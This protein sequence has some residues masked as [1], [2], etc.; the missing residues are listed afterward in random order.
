[1]RREE[2]R[3]RRRRRLQQ[4]TPGS[5]DPSPGARYDYRAAPEELVDRA[6]TIAEICAHHDTTLPA[7]ALAFSLAHPAVISA[8][9]GARSSEQVIR[10]C[11]LYARQPPLALW[12]E[13][14]A[15]GLI[16]DDAPFPHAGS[17]RVTLTMTE[18]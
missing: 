13:L 1:M 7:V 14:T 5:S 9:V 8:C 12:R 15:A 3:D 16:R 6:Q 11:D 10:N 2:D 4:R 18:R 17:R